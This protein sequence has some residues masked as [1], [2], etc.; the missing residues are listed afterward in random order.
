MS[1]EEETPTILGDEGEEEETPTRTT[2]SRIATR[3]RLAT[4]SPGK[5]SISIILPTT[6]SS[7][8]P[9]DVSSIAPSGV[10][11][12]IPTALP[13]ALPSSLPN[14]TDEVQ[15]P[16]GAGI[17]IGD[18]LYQNFSTKEAAASY[19]TLNSSVTGCFAQNGAMPMLLADRDLCLPGF[20]CPNSTDLM[21]P[22]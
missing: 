17:M 2:S 18:T 12:D 11:S 20:Y 6:V 9:F 16:A 14:D 8:L 13:S 3:T 22:Q 19:R 7:D 4:T 10:L 1:G 15:L 21:P 5:P